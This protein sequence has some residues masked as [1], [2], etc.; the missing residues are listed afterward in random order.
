MIKA[1]QA[2]KLKEGEE[3]KKKKADIYKKQ[4]Q[5]FFHYI[6]QTPGIFKLLVQ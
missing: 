4:L 6:R 2:G 5:P 3:L 1:K